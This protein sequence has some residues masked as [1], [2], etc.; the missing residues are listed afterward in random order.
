MKIRGQTEV[1]AFGHLPDAAHGIY[2]DWGN[3]LGQK[4]WGQF[5][6]SP[7]YAQGNLREERERLGHL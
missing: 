2:K 3:L 7:N 5:R 6:L 4:K 1:T